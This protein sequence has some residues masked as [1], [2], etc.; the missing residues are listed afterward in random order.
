[1]CKLKMLCSS[2]F[3]LISFFRYSV[4]INL[5]QQNAP[6]K[7]RFFHFL[8][9]TIICYFCANVVFI[10]KCVFIVLYV[11]AKDKGNYPPLPAAYALENWQKYRQ[12]LLLKIPNKFSFILMFIENHDINFYY[13]NIIYLFLIKQTEVFTW[14]TL[15]KIF[16]F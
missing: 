14:L 3:T 10:C 9:T 12:S 15:I 6:E 1:M 13:N 16:H 7:I 8:Y 11:L 5:N 2:N 4:T